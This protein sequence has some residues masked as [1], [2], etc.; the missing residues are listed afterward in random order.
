MKRPV[1]G[2]RTGGIIGRMSATVEKVVLEALG[3]PPA[4]R[5]FVAEQL[6]ENLDAPD[7]LPLSA[8]W[9]KNG[10]RRCGLFERRIEEL[11]RE[12]PS[13]GKTSANKFQALEKPA[14]ANLSPPP[15]ST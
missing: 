14:P 12:F 5:A 15:Q 3:L 7:A 6:I 1:D 2:R 13:S 11:E 10:R 4:L 9:K 8:K